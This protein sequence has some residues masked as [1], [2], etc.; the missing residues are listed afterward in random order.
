V[1]RRA[2]RRMLRSRPVHTSPSEPE[3]H[4]LVQLVSGSRALAAPLMARPRENG[5]PQL[6]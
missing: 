2:P 5:P 3:L 1:V 6:P 4:G